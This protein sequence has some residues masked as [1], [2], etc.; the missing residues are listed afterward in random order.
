MNL[1]SGYGGDGERLVAQIA[2]AGGQAPPVDA[3]MAETLAEPLSPAETTLLAA[4][5]PLAAHSPRDAKRLLNA[6]R[7]ARCSNLPR[8][9]IALMLAV[10]LANDETQAIVRDK[11]AQGYDLTD[12]GISGPL[13][14]INAV[15]AVRA[16]SGG[17]GVS[18]DDARAAFEIARRYTLLV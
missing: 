5:A 9:A 15:R 11:L 7:L 8:P 10:A 13:P 1:P 6:Y 14:L 12:I 3:K 2:F 18:Q 17:G 4:L 16:A